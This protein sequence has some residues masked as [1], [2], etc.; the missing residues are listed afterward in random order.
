MPPLSGAPQV[1]TLHD[2]AVHPDLQGFRIGSWLLR[3]MT[4]Q[5]SGHGVYDVGTVT[6]AELQ[7]FFR[8]VSFSLDREGSLPMALSDARR[9]Q[10]MEEGAGE[11]ITAGIAANEELQQL[12]QRVK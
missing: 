9:E 1:A 7:P 11:A 6:P 3:S 12:L 5:I 10:L 8:G 2:L 4:H